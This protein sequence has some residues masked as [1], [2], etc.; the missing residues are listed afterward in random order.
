MRV[1]AF[2]VAAA[3]VLAACGKKTETTDGT[4]TTTD[5]PPAAATT[6]TTHTV[7][8][9]ESRFDPTTLTI[10]SGDIVVFKGISGGP[11]NVQFTDSLPPATVTA[12]DAGIADKAATL[13]SSMAMDGSDITVSFK[14]VPAGTYNIL[15][16]P[17]LAN[18]MKMTVTVT[19]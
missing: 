6:G 14:D 19:Q 2:M 5:T 13:T 9:V 16:Q 17:H 3:L 8:M 10:K 4:T 7:Q 15:C 18:G 12:L 1:P 11:H